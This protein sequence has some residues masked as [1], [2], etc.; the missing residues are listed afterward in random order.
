MPGN[1]IDGISATGSTTASTMSQARAAAIL[2]AGPEEMTMTTEGRLRE[3]GTTATSI[4]M[5]TVDPQDSRPAPPPA[6]IRVDNLHYD[7]TEEDIMVSFYAS[8]RKVEN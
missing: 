6:K 8:R 5:T 7:L 3:T 2:E 1:L 4:H